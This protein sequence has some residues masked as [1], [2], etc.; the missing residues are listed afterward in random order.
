M[1]FSS[2]QFLFLFLPIFL[3]FL[4][5]FKKYK[6][7]IVILFSVIFMYLIEKNFIFFLSLICLFNFFLAKKIYSKKILFFG[8]FTNLS[9]LIYYKYL[10]FFLESLNYSTI[11]H[12]VLPAGI[13]FITFHSISYLIDVYDKKIN[14]E[15]NFSNFF[16]FIFM[17]PQVISGPITRFSKVYK[18]LNILKN[19][20]FKNGVYLIYIGLLQKVIIA[21]FLSLYVDEFYSERNLQV[22]LNGF[23]A[24]M[25]GTVYILQLYFDFSGYTH[26]A[27]G[28]GLIIGV[29]LPKNF[30]FPLS[31]NTVSEFWK[32]WHISLSSF[33]RDYL[34]IKINQKFKIGAKEN[35]IKY[36]YSILF[37]M[38]LSGIWHGANQTFLVWGFSHG[39]LICFEKIFNLEK[40][41]KI[42]LKIY[43]IFALSFT[44]IYFRAPSVEFAYQAIRSIT[45]NFELFDAIIHKYVNYR[46]ILTIF[47]SLFFINA[48]NK[49][50]LL[51]IKRYML[52]SKVGNCFLILLT[53]FLF[54]EL[55]S[56]NFAP[57]IYFRF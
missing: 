27:I 13:S 33:I 5:L 25:V 37:C 11:D 45:A 52:S 30:N 3:L 53:I 54:F 23:D 47:L 44:F 24:L 56:Q 2:V 18:S 57:F 22:G 34:F 41:N 8:I 31:S 38:S 12:I 6:K 20:Y 10:N 7:I 21:D 32:R 36:F 9:I 15:K 49:Y 26:I 19:F 17:F 35:S 50:R 40:Q 28:L 43:I 1:V 29:R 48:N 16:L 14:A 51:S 39:L 55:V 42:F 46:F 4:F